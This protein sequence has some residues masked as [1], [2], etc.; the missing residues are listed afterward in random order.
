MQNIVAEQ[1]RILPWISNV[2]YIL[3]DSFLLFTVNQ[4]SLTGK[5]KLENPL[6]F[7]EIKKTVNR[8]IENTFLFTEI[9]KIEKEMCKIDS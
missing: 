8:Y 2:L 3:A 1:K 4:G 7:S 6:F 9:E 5:N